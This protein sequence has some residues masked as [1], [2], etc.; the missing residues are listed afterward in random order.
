[1]EIL[2]YPVLITTKI[3]PEFPKFRGPAMVFP[4]RILQF[5]LTD[6][7]ISKGKYIIV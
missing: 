3:Y 4:Y 2:P 7:F 1:M 6:L 5:Y